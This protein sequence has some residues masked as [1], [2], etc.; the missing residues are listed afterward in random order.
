MNITFHVCSN[1]CNYISHTVPFNYSVVVTFTIRRSVASET[2]SLSLKYTPC[3]CTHLQTHFHTR[4]CAHTH[5]RTAFPPWVGQFIPAIR[6]SAAR[7]DAVISPLL[8]CCIWRMKIKC[9]Y[10][11]GGLIS[12]P[13]GR[14]LNY[15]SLYP[16][17]SLRKALFFSCYFAFKACDLIIHFIIPS[18]SVSALPVII[19]CPFCL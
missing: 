6:E 8:F 13:Q 5:T 4:A 18:V 14:A 11:R 17:K 10:Q 1:S 3:I 2:L 9:R 12:D 7:R 15:C 19:K 16:A